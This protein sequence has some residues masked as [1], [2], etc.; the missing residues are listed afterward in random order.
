VSHEDVR[1]AVACLSAEQR[2]AYIKLVRQ[3]YRADR[4]E[5]QHTVSP[6]SSAPTRLASPTRAP[7][8]L[9]PAPA[10]ASEQ[11]QKDPAHRWHVVGPP[12]AQA[13]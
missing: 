13:C 2:R 8:A 9:A 10:V 11:I 6:P 1:L 12:S 7:L 5:Y 4:R 3:Q